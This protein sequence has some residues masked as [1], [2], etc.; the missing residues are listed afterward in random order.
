MCANACRQCA[1]LLLVGTRSQILASGGLPTAGQGQ[2]RETSAPPGRTALILSAGA[3]FGAYQAGVWMALEGRFTPDVVIGASVGSL[4]GWAI[5]GGLSA[6]SLSARWQ[7]LPEARHIRLQWP[8][9]PL[10]GCVQASY[11]ASWVQEL[12]QQLQPRAEFGVVVTRVWPLRPE[13]VTTPQVTWQHLASSCSMPFLYPHY[14]LNG[15]L[16]TDGGLLQALPLWA[17]KEF[18]CQRVVAV[19][20]LPHP[21][22]WGG[23]LASRTMRAAGRLRVANPALRLVSIQ[24]SKPLGSIRDFM[25]WT[26]ANAR[27][28]IDQGQ[29]DAEAALEEIEGLSE[30]DARS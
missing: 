20:V 24:P 1:T 9:H 25:L 19:N 4:N 16:Y 23:R 8:R 5:A 28:W 12:H 15:T 17:A 27:R 29:R 3:M 10:A 2:Q 21:L 6:T 11:L 14:R 18:G 13:L 26:P 22:F 7:E 30:I